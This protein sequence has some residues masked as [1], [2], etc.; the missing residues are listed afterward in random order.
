[1]EI[2]GSVSGLIVW[3]SLSLAFIRYTHWYD[4]CIF[5]ST[6]DSI[7]IHITGSRNATTT[8]HDSF[9]SISA[10]PKTISPSP[11]S[12]GHSPCPPGSVLS[13][14]SSSSASRALRGGAAPSPSPRSRSHTQR[15]VTDHLHT[16]LIPCTGLL[17]NHR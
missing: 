17:H 15:Y 4:F 5:C 16:C 6:I 9:Q 12:R 3:A 10:T 8:S 13:A 14:A 7:L 11:S 2:S 1:M